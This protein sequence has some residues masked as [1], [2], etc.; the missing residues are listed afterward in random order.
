MFGTPVTLVSTKVI[1][2]DKEEIMPCVIARVMPCI[3]S[4][5]ILCVTSCVIHCVSLEFSLFDS[6]ARNENKEMTP[7]K[8]SVKPV[9][10]SGGNLMEITGKNNT[11][12]LSWIKFSQLEGL[13]WFC[14]HFRHKLN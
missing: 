10:K 14:S 8:P 4:C 11:F 1:A 9:V 7:A 3:I 5:V 12:S 6:L 13:V 2:I